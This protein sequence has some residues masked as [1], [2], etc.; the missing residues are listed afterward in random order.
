VVQARSLEKSHSS[1][2]LA[3][4]QMPAMGLLA[5]EPDSTLYFCKSQSTTSPFRML[6]LSNSSN[7]SVAF[8]VKTTA[9]KAY[10]VRPSSG[11]LKPSENQEVQIILQAQ[12]QGESAT[13]AQ[14]RFLVQAVAVGESEVVT[15]EDWAKFP[16]DRVHEQ[17]LN[18]IVEDEDTEVVNTAVPDTRTVVGGGADGATDLKV[19]YDELVQYTLTLEKEKKKLEAELAASVS[20][21]GGSGGEGFTKATLILAV[22]VAFLVPYAA[23]FLGQ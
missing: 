23:K 18:V 19:K 8:K 9:P 7:G 6:K 2:A 12:P 4:V 3:S 14:D 11:V 5:L 20:A 15:R 1:E 10:L 21:K 13:N 16:K 17:K 22:L